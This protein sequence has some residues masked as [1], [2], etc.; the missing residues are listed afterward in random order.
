MNF[1]NVGLGG[2]QHS[3]LLICYFMIHFLPSICRG[4]SGGPMFSIRDQKR[5]EL[6]A[7]KCFLRP[8]SFLLSR[9]IMMWW[10]Q[11]I[12][13]FSCFIKTMQVGTVTQHD[14][15][16]DT[17]GVGIYLLWFVHTFLWMIWLEHFLIFSFSL[18]HHTYQ[19]TEKNS[20]KYRAKIWL[21]W[22]SIPIQ[23]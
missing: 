18:T 3:Q 8:L 1:Q 14:S 11:Y 12:W 19:E 22:G 23:Y 2:G 7:F 20:I 6:V 13:A 21:S 5:Y 9:W 10:F 4:D 16:C 17:P 15:Y